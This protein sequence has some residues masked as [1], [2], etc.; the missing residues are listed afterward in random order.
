MKKELH[1]D[2]LIFEGDDED[3]AYVM[4]IQYHDDGKGVN[5]P[6]SEEIY[7]IFRQAD[8]ENL[9][10]AHEK[11]LCPDCIEDLQDAI[12]TFAEAQNLVNVPPTHITG[13]AAR[14][15]AATIALAMTAVLNDDGFEE[16]EDDDN[17]GEDDTAPA[18]KKPHEL[19]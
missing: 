7:I 4:I 9:I 8:V 11:H 12:N 15:M 17:E 5:I 10:A 13:A 14:A 3:P 1:F 6:G 18:G 19:N 2:V 16:S